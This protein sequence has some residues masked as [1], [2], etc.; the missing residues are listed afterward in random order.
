MRIVMPGVESIVDVLA[1]E[2]EE[3]EH[4]HTGDNIGATS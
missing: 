1:G 2:A 4:D 3:R